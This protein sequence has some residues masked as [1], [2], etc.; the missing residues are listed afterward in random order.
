MNKTSSITFVVRI[1]QNMNKEEL[2]K[3]RLKI[4]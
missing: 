2:W 3:N 1:T 4:L